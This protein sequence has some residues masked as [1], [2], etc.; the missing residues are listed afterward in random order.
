VRVGLFYPDGLPES[1]AVVANNIALELAALGCDV[2]RFNTAGSPPGSVD[3]LWDP[4]AGGGAAP[5]PE[6]LGIGVPLVVTLHG[7]AP[8]A[9][10]AWEYYGSF[11]EALRGLSANARK[12]R[13][14]AGCAS[15]CAAVV[16]VSDSSRTD[17]LRKLPIPPERV[18][19]CHN[20]VDHSVFHARSTTEAHSRGDYFFHISNNEPRKNVR[21][22]C[23]AHAALPRGRR[24]RLV[25]KLPKPLD[26]PVAE[27][28]EVITRRLE[29]S[30]LADIYAGC[31][32]FIFPSLFEGFGIPIV[33]SMACGGP[34]ITSSS[35]ACAEVAG[36]AA[37]LVDPR[38][39]S[40][41]RDAMAEVQDPFVANR[42]VESGLKRAAEFTW[43][44]A[45]EHYAG[46]FASV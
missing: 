34:V 46:I 25:L 1:F 37:L 6:L 41:I 3:V 19:W 13:L 28:V 36:E 40:Q 35:G 8:M 32:A 43:K 45:A 5:Q 7:V 15:A 30:E 33:E 9:I 10:P 20:A 39:I 17:I 29:D 4:R 42:C 12:R 23:E 24:P 27:D 21:R 2:R 44:K 38:S 22:I 16:T 31:A 14:W 11:R 26:F 18:S